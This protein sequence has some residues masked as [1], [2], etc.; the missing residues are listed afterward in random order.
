[1]IQLRIGK[2]L[3]SMKAL[4]ED[5][6]EIGTYDLIFLDADKVLPFCPNV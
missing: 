2:A 5:S 6:K 1:V 3:E 4:S